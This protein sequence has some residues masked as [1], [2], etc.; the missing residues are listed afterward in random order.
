MRR[1]S[2]GRRGSRVD[3]ISLPRFVLSVVGVCKD[4]LADLIAKF[5][6]PPI[7]QRVLPVEAGKIKEDWRGAARGAGG[8][9][10]AGVGAGGPRPRPA[11]PRGGGVWWAPPGPRG[12]RGAVRDR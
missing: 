4:V 2:P 6:R 5:G 12:E 9:T 11:A 3:L 7:I 10:F 8:V 1:A